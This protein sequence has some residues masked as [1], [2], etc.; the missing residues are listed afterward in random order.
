MKITTKAEEKKQRKYPV[1]IFQN[2]PVQWLTIHSAMSI[3][4][5]E[6][7]PILMDDMRVKETYLTAVS[8]IS[9]AIPRLIFLDLSLP[10]KEAGLA[11]L[12]QIKA[13]LR[14]YKVPIIILNNSEVPEEVLHAYVLGAASYIT[15][16]LNYSDWLDCFYAF[17][18]HWWELAKLPVST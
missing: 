9:Q 2:D 14:F 10:N 15:K 12:I 7:E 18:P 8:D 6:I 16:P 17:R 11:L 3:C 5:P 1:F 4:F 13:D